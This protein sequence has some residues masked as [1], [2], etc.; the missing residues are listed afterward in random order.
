MGESM[1]ELVYYLDVMSSWCLYAEPNLEKLRHRYAPRLGYDWRISLITDLAGSRERVE[2]FYKRSGS[3]SGLH[4]NPA[5]CQESVSTL[6]ANL[7]AEAAR[8]LGFGDDRVRL[9]LARAAM[10][11]GISIVQKAIAANIVARVTGLAPEKILA[12]M[13]DAK[14]KERIQRTS[15]EFASYQIDQRPAFVLRSSIG[16][17]AILSGIWSFEPLDATVGAMLSDV[18]KYERFAADNPPLP[19]LR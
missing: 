7:A 15:E 17:T 19:A 8:T 14:V 3:I 13:D 9:A 5:W 6:D 12:T 16:D 11:D 1:V 10:I 4:L 2:W 18:E